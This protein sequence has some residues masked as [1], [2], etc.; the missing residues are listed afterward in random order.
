[1]YRDLNP[2][3][4]VDT[5]LNEL[6]GATGQGISLGVIEV[7]LEP[8][9]ETSQLDLSDAFTIGDVMEIFQSQLGVTLQINPQQTGFSVQ[10]PDGQS[11]TIRDVN[12]GRTAQDLGIDDVFNGPISEAGRDLD[13]R[14]TDNTPVSAF[15]FDLEMI[16][17]TNGI[18]ITDL[19]LSSAETVGDI[20]RIVEQLDMGIRIDISQ[21]GDRLDV[22]NLRSG[23]LMSVGE[24]PGSQ[25]ATDLGI[26][27]MDRGTLLS[28]FN[29]GEGVSILQGGVDPV[30]GN[31][32]P[33]LDQD[34]VVK[35]SNGE[36]FSVNLVGCQTVGDVLDK[37]RLRADQELVDPN[38]L[39]VGLALK[40]NGIRL[41]DT[42]GGGG[43]FRLEALNGS[44]ALADLGLATNP[45]GATIVGEDRAMV[46]VEGLFTHLMDLRDALMAGDVPGISIA[47]GWLEGDLDRLGLVQAEVGIRTNRITDAMARNEDTIIMDEQLRSGILNLD[48][49]EASI[50]FASLQ[51][52]LQAGMATAAR[53]V[54]MTL[55]DY[56]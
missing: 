13:R 25:T 4:D 49:T 26:R 30:T 50:R 12:G 28:D 23:S 27:S 18:Q 32:D 56:L 3:L 33:S 8:T 24:L 35:L 10:V 43:E 29:R 39:D 40:G 20:R 42:S 41:G 37:I 1:G 38:I 6:N 31:L 5:P 21:S 19:D 15:D 55:L 36:S 54:S 47:S 51:Q 53:S 46:A 48:Y 52:Q 17:F 44:D 45:D 2:A 11:I 34:F 9:G 14:L 16:R 22:V 7:V